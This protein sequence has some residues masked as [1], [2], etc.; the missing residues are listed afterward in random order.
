MSQYEISFILEKPNEKWFGY[1]LRTDPEGGEHLF[2][3]KYIDIIIESPFEN[4]NVSK[5]I[6]PF[7]AKDQDEAKKI[8]TNLVVDKYYTIR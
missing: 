3:K 8:Y 7:T 6:G 4:P 2:V 1:A 5:I